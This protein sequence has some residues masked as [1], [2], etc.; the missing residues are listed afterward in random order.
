MDRIDKMDDY[1]LIPEPREVKMLPGFYKLT[2]EIIRGVLNFRAG[3]SLPQG[4]DETADAAIGDPEAY[5]LHIRPGGIKIK[6]KTET[7]TYYAICTLKQ[8]FRQ[9]SDHAIRCM[10]IRDWPDFPHRAIMLDVSR[11]RVPTMESLY[12]RI[13]MWGELKYNQL[14]LYMEHTFAYHDHQKVWENAS[15]FTAG[16]IRHIEGYCRKHAIELVP[17]QN[18]FGHMERWLVHPEYRKLAE[19]P[20]GFTDPWGIFRKTP[21]TLS[22]AEPST[23]SFLKSLYDELLPN[24]ESRFFNIGGD[25]TYELGMGIS[26]KLCEEIGKEKVYIN[27]IDELRRLAAARGKRIMVYADMILQFPHIPGEISDDIIL[28]EW[29]YESNHP[30]ERNTLRLKESGLEFYV[31]AGTSSWNSIGGRWGNAKGNIR[32]AAFYGRKNGAVGFLL[33]DW[34]DNG[35]WQQPIISIP[36][37]FYAAQA[38]WNQEKIEMLNMEHVLDIHFFDD[39]TASASKALLI[40]QDIYKN[41]RF[42]LENFS[43]QAALLLDPVFPYLRPAYKHFR[44]YKFED[45]L[46]QIKKAGELLEKAEGK[47]EQELLHEMIFSLK[48][49]K[50]ACCLGSFLFSTKNLKITEIPKEKRKNLSEEIGELIGDYKILW[51]RDS[52]PGGLEDSSGRLEKL[53]EIYDS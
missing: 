33:T 4:I 51:L 15:P 50:H 43:I 5:I 7:G 47:I 30:F 52:R 12:K 21:S 26:K 1:L 31:C 10:T 23:I 9:H 37:C 28:L 16:E 8:V 20:E 53:R 35:H 34:G 42:M 14:Q 13:E 41:D 3:D 36:A 17:N 48:L 25:E 39:F 45:E 19:S 46:K 29:G 38:A 27:F 22:P 11:D 49:L 2:E 44:G 32:K 24:F 18:S 40:M 6:S